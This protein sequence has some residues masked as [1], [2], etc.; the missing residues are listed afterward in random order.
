MKNLDYDIITDE[1][2]D[3]EGLH[4]L[5][6]IAVSCW[7][8]TRNMS[9]PGCSMRWRHT[10]R[11]ADD[12]FHWGNALYWRVVYHPAIPGVMELR[13]CEVG[14]G[15]ITDPGESCHAFGGEYG[16]L[17]ERIGRPP[18]KTLGSGFIG[19]GFDRCTYFRRQPDSDNPR[20]AFVFEGMKGDIIGDF[21][22]I[23]GARPA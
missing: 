14:N 7:P 20:V 2:L 11:R 22:L 17:W 4:A 1:D 15:W 10:A 21:G 8:A 3:R 5:P 18:H 13:R 16:G 23:G 12:W 6:P 9:R 19:Q